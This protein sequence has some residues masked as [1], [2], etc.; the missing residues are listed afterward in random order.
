M[1]YIRENV[2]EGLGGVALD[3]LGLDLVLGV[4]S[5]LEDVLLLEELLLLLHELLEASVVLAAR[6]GLQTACLPERH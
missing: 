6:D 1:S 4:D 2:L 3:P 5:P